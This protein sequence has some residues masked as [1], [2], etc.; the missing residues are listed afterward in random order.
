M[1]NLKNQFNPGEFIVGGRP[2]LSGR[3]VIFCREEEIAAELLGL[4]PEKFYFAGAVSGTRS[5][6]ENVLA[7]NS[8]EFIERAIALT[9]GAR[10]TRT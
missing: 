9:G 4:D 2:E 1:N 3:T 10:G 5:S 8:P 7:Y 6:R